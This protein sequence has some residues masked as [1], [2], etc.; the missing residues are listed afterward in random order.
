MPPE[1]L[2]ASKEY[3]ED[4]NPVGVWL[5]E[6]YDFTG[7]RR[8][9]VSTEDLR[10]DFD[11]YKGQPSITSRRFG[12]YMSLSGRS[13]SFL[14]VRGVSLHHLS[15]SLLLLL[16]C[17]LSRSAFA[18]SFAAS[19][20]PQHVNILLCGHNYISSPR[21]HFLSTISR[22]MVGTSNE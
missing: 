7:Q 15:S 10:N 14:V 6:N 4:N 12:N 17:A 16:R 2:E 8:D 21:T 5:K 18:S 13:L 20:S 22:R 9:I 11:A 1:V 3:I 19:Y